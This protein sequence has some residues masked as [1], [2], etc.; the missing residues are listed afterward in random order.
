MKKIYLIKHFILLAI[1]ISGNAY[2]QI[3]SVD[4][5]SNWQQWISSILGGN[6]VEISNIE[7]N[8]RP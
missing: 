2:S 7:I 4:T 8:I 1:L 5:S 3:I 6:C